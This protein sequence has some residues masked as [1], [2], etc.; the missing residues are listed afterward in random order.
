MAEKGGKGYLPPKGGKS[1]MKSPGNFLC[2][3]LFVYRSP[4]GY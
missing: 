1:A 4:L 2:L 3:L